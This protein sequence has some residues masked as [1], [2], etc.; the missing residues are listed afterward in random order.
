[1]MR[2]PMTPEQTF[3]YLGFMLGA[4]PPLAIFIRVLTGGAS[5]EGLVLFFMI[6]INVVSAL[7]GYFFGKVVARMVRRIE[8]RSWSVML[9]ILPFVGLLWGMVAGGAGAFIVFIVGAIFGAMIGGAVGAIALPVFV[10]FHRLLKRG[11]MIERRHFLPLAFGLTF[12][13]CS[14]ILGL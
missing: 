4:F 3:A 9:L 12:T 11:D 8:K 1:M 5:L 7:A 10:V 14:F 2:S 13:I 6:A